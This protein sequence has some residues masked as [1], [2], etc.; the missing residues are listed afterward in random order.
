[1]HCPSLLCHYTYAKYNLGTMYYGGEG[2]RQDYQKALELYQL[3]ANQGD[4]DAQYNLGYMYDN[5]KGIRQNKASAKEWFGKACDN[6][7]QSSCDA[8]EMLN[9][10]GY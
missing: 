3:A 2:V 9:E 7:D 5:G 4:V 1:M 6:G 8:Y 10:D